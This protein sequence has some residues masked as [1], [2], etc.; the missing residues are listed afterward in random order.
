M[1]LL[2]DSL[3]R[4]EARQS[5]DH[6]KTDLELTCTECGEIVCDIEHGDTLATLAAVADEHECSDEGEDEEDEG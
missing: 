3:H 4:F 5:D 6:V 2:H 1:A